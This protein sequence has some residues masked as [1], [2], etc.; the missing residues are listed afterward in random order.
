MN[1]TKRKE[2]SKIKAMLDDAKTK[3]ESII[4]EEQDCFDN[5]TEGLQQTAMGQAMEDAISNMED[6]AGLIEEAIESLDSASI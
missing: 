2:L 3:I 4:D 1:N 6:A 5:L